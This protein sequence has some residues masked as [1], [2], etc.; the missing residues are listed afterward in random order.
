MY[1][2]LTQGKR[3]QFLQPD[4]CDSLTSD[5][6]IHGVQKETSVFT[7]NLTKGLRKRDPTNLT[8][9]LCFWVARCNSL[10][11][12]RKT[13]AFSAV[14]HQQIYETRSFHWIFFFPTYD[15]TFHPVPSWFMQVTTVINVIYQ[16]RRITWAPRI[17]RDVK[18]GCSREDVKHMCQLKKKYFGSNF[19]GRIMWYVLDR[20]FLGTLNLW[21]RVFP[22][23]CRR[24]THSGLFLPKLLCGKSEN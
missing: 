17:N 23:L 19:S 18:T 13:W 7:I 8:D 3:K 22:F 15:F 14:P 11:S 21:W 9:L 6:E 4:V 12:P 24:C 16:V 1:Y 10:H 2:L 5:T 20:Q